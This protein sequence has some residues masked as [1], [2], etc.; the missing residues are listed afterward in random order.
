MHFLETPIE[1]LKG[2]GPMRAELLK[3]ELHIF[4]FSDLLCYYPFRYID[5]SVI[6]KVAELNADMP[7]IQLKGKIVRFEEKGQKRAKRLIAY[8]QD[9]TGITE[10]IWFKGIRW[11]KKGIKTNVE[12]LVFG[13]PS[14]YQRKINI[15]HPEMDV[16]EKQQSISSS[17]QSVYSTTELLSS[18]GLNSR[19]IRK[20]TKVL[21]QQ[22]ENK[23]QE[24]LSDSLLSRLKL[25][26]K[27]KAL[28]DIHFP[29]DTNSLE[30]AQK[31][32]KF[33]ELFFL[34]FHLLKMKLTRTKKYEG[35]ILEKVDNHFENYFKNH[36]QFELTNAQKK[37]LKEI[38]IDV[39][40]DTNGN[41]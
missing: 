5:R 37:V 4:S 21:Y 41:R 9:E 26:K 38:R 6:H 10:L 24:T 28:I 11:I 39:K 14:A 33:E 12:Y 30:R 3:K 8:F 7:Y 29:A 13:K 18:K 32:L 27:E 36:L 2:V 1:Y 22:I 31:R 40:K 25:P 19:G 35:F 17:L 20:L 15:V 34:Q 23:I 16:F